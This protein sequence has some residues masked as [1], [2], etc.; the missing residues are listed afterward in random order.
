MMPAALPPHLTRTPGAV[1][2][3]YGLGVAAL[4]LLG[5][6]PAPLT[7]EPSLDGMTAEPSGVGTIAELS[8]REAVERAGSPLLHFSQPPLPLS[9]A[10]TRIAE[11]AG[12]SV[13]IEGQTAGLTSPAL[14]GAM[15]LEAALDVALAGSG[16]R[17]GYTTEGRLAVTLPVKEP[18]ARTPADAASL[19]TIVL[20]ATGQP[21]QL[22]DAPATMTVIQAADLRGRRATS[23]ADLLRGL[24]G[25][26]VSAPG[27]EGLPALSIRGMG[28]SYLMFL[29]DGRPLSASEEAVYNGQG[30]NSKIG[31]LPP[32]TALQR[33][34]VIRGP[35]SSLYGSAAAGGVINV[36]TRDI[37]QTWG[38]EIT[39]EFA[40]GLQAG[41]GAGRG[42]R[43]YLGGPLVTDRLALALY[44]ADNRHAEDDLARSGYQQ[45]GSGQAR[46][47]VYGARLTYA[48]D[49]RQSF[50][51][52]LQQ[53][54]LSF[55][56]SAR[57]ALN[58]VSTRV[59]DTRA[60][61]T[62][63][64]TWREGLTTAS[65]VQLERTD[66]R[67]GNESGHDAVVLNSRSTLQTASGSLT[68][69]YEYRTE[70]TRHDPDRLLGTANPVLRRWHQSLFL[71]GD[72]ALG[73]NAV[74]T[75]GLRADH[76]EK[77]G[78]ALTPRAH[79]VWHLTPQL[80]LKGGIGN[81][82]R[83]PALKQA[84]DAVAEPSG[85]NGQSRDLGNSALRPE[86]STNYE[87]G[88]IWDSGQG[89]Q[90]GATLYHSRFHD[91]ISRTDLCRTPAGAAPACLLDGNHW[92]AVTRY[93]NEDSAKL[94]GLELTLDL[95]L[96]ETML[97]ANYTLSDSKITRGRNQGQ[98]FNSLPHHALT[99][100]L[101]R[102]IGALTLWAEGRWRSKA[103]SSGTAAPAHAMLDIGL[104]W[105]MND[106]V[107]G[108]FMIYNLSDRVWAGETPEG[109][110]IWLGLTSRF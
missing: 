97:S 2:L 73:Q 100:S 34:E 1:K 89:P 99:I 38:G 27:R 17:Y 92:V 47:Q 23:F 70:R 88:L 53:S 62:H 60:A 83:V 5:L 54:Q 43:Y 93:V 11:N 33:I 52:D 95:P 101:E 84:D 4:V 39:T 86:R 41:Q 79:L 18:G 94:S 76:N 45:R 66:F 49:Q 69:G 72:M 21:Q 98:P 26:S 3:R 103:R 81:G 7:A 42:L 87:I 44:G 36:I 82:Y 68:L 57:S 96:G 10:L 110:R 61:L 56:R 35:M 29:V 14:R 67:T 58:P 78:Y 106:Q 19:G 65:F 91:R 107:T 20:S 32:V 105:E 75:L 16:G 55:S 37:P 6:L 50:S 108:S 46:R 25:L 12:L 59:R 9:R 13:V 22:T 40:P 85:G 90:L 74:L 109:R 51:L 80:T 30:S 31:F 64:I 104:N 8:G 71:E 63:R 102:P 77:Y 15:S 28:Q 24:P 48:P